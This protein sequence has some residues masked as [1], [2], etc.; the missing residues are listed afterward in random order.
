M[1]IYNLHTKEKLLKAKHWKQTKS[2]QQNT[3]V[4]YILL[5]VKKKASPAKWIVKGS[6][7]QNEQK[8]SS[9]T[10]ITRRDKSKRNGEK[11]KKQ[12]RTK[13]CYFHTIYQAGM[14][15]HIL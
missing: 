15:I 13:C 8:L 6:N 3:H 5:C 1:A 14:Q 9:I 10:R 11:S 4:I 7:I 12:K 2:A